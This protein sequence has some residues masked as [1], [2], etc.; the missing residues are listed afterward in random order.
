MDDDLGIEWRVSFRCD[1]KPGLLIRESPVVVDGLAKTPLWSEL[2]VQGVWSEEH[3]RVEPTGP[4]GSIASIKKL[5]KS[6]KAVYLA[7]GD[8]DALLER[9]RPDVRLEISPDNTGLAL[10]AIVRV[11]SLARVGVAA[12]DAYAD[13][14]ADLAVRWRSSGVRMTEAWACPTR[15]STPFV[16]PQM[17]PPRVTRP[18]RQRNAIVDVLDAKIPDSPRHPETAIATRALAIAAVP[19]GVR[20]R[21]RDGVVIL[22]WVDDPCDAAAIAKAAAHE[23]WLYAL[24]PSSP[25]PPY[26][27]DGDLRLPG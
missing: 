27:E 17:R 24:L 22:R 26:N 6:G 12:V 7:R 11:E 20:R 10:R 14:L 16:Y 23:R 18:S 25:E 15:R 5:V 8:R 13:M 4:L 21:E 9:S 19:E 3:E 1:D 2:Q